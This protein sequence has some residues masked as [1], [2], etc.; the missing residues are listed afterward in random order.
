M[1]LHS[2]E[3]LKLHKTNCI[4]F[5]TALPSLLKVC[6]CSPT[7]TCLVHA[8]RLVLHQQIY[9]KE[10]SINKNR[11][12][13]RY[14]PNLVMVLGSACLYVFLTEHIGL[15]HCIHQCPGSFWAQQS[16]KILVILN[17]TGYMLTSSGFAAFI[18]LRYILQIPSKMIGK[19]PEVLNFQPVMSRTQPVR[20]QLTASSYRSYRTWVFT[21]KCGTINK[22]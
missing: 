17:P 2:N 3:A 13:N 14:F 1:V 18:H 4:L 22:I 16:V 20:L 7:S 15:P 21:I 6:G 12:E 9:N 19:F 5:R 8:T 11:I 10:A